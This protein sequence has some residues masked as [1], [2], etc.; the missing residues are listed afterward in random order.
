[1]MIPIV[2]AGVVVA[3]VVGAVGFGMAQ[4]MRPRRMTIVDYPELPAP[5]P[6]E[7]NEPAG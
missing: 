5:K 4:I 2:L 1:M 3:G 7:L 6:E